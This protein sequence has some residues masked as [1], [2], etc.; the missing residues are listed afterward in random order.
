ME[1]KTDKV[2]PV[3]RR[4]EVL[5]KLNA[6]NLQLLERGLLGDLPDRFKPGFTAIKGPV[7]GE[8]NK[9]LVVA[10]PTSLLSAC[11]P[12]VPDSPSP[13]ENQITSSEDESASPLKKTF[14]FRERF[15]RISFFGKDKHDKTK[16]KQEKTILE[17]ER[18]KDTPPPMLQKSGIKTDTKQKSS[19]RF[20]LFRNKELVE[21]RQKQRPVYT[22]S[23]S[24]EFLPRALDENSERKCSLTK[25]SSYA[26]GSSDTMGDAWSSNESLEYLSN[27]YYDNEDTVF[28]KSIKEIP[29]HGSSNNNSSLSTVSGSSGLVVNVLKTKS[30]QDLLDEFDKTVDMFS[31][32]YLSDCEPYT[33]TSDQLPVK[34]K[35]KSSSFSTLP[36]PKVVQ[37]TKVNKINEDFK[38]ELSKMLNVKRE[39]G[40]VNRNVRRGSVTDWFVLEDKAMSA[41]CAIEENKYR[42]AQK[43]PTKRVRRISSTKYF[44]AYSNIKA[45]FISLLA[46]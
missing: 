23:K 27:V 41:A 44:I 3:L 42:R 45:T 43:K 15:S 6:E 4:A 22:R 30:I 29:I 33:K 12:V 31:E 10:K 34:E 38:T 28:L 17:D 39:S 26:F 36:S 11:L 1:N 25:N 2:K 20:W 40:G 37:V 9:E 19:K 35:R 18:I 8:L 13:S 46:L 21:R 7:R 32:N 24:F 5:K 14:S 16:W